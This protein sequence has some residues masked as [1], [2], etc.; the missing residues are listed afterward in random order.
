MHVPPPIL[1]L[2]TNTLIFKPLLA[3]QSKTIYKNNL[4][5]I[6][7]EQSNHHFGML[8]KEGY[9]NKHMQEPA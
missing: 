2:F 5:K 8:Y 7:K 4:R 9:S 6:K 3:L 1:S